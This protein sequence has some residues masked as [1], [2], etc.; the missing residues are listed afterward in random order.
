MPKADKN[1]KDRLLQQRSDLESDLTV[2]YKIFIF[3]LS[4]SNLSQY[5]LYYP[6]TMKYISL[7]AS[8]ESG[9][10]ESTMKMKLIARN[11]ALKSREDDIKVTFL[12]YS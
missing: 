1:D 9:D 11:M 12:T 5:V 7:F 6:K 4:H 3:P 10:G 8:K 2:F